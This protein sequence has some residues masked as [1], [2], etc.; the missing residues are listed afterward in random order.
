MGRSSGFSVGPLLSI[1]ILEYQPSSLGATSLQG[2]IQGL[3][4]DP[5]LGLATPA[6]ASQ[7]HHLSSTEGSSCPSLLGQ[8]RRNPGLANLIVAPVEAGL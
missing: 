8:S 1:D 7:R 6:Q 3:L 5:T 4:C 2:L